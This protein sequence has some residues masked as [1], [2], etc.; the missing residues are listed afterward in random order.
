MFQ[1]LNG[2]DAQND[3]G[4]DMELPR[5]WWDTAK[6][7][8]LWEA[9][10]IPAIQQLRQAAAYQAHGDNCVCAICSGNIDEPSVVS[11]GEKT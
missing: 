4:V 3:F 2:A 9:Y 1:I 8:E 6:H 10:V 11:A 5:E 7:P